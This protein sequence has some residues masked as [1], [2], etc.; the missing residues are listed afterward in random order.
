MSKYSFCSRFKLYLITAM[1]HCDVKNAS[2]I[3][4]QIVFK[5]LLIFRSIDSFPFG[6]LD[7]YQYDVINY[8]FNMST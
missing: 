4:R 7:K 6:Y 1:E 3:S 8:E 2:M 5:F